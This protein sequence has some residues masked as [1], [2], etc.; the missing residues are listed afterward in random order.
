[1]LTGRILIVAL[2]GWNDATEAASGALSA[3]TEQ[4]DAQTLE[5][6]DPQEYYDFQLF[7]PMV[8]LDEEGNR[9]IIWPSTELLQ[10]SKENI[11]QNPELD[12]LYLLV[13]AEPSRRWLAF[14]AE[15]LEMVQD[16]E[17]DQ[18]IMLGSMFAEV[19]HTRPM[20]V[21]K[22]T[23]NKILQESMQIETSNYEGLV[24][25][26]AILTQAFE[27]EG[28]PVLSLWGSVPHYVHNAINPKGSLGFLN[29]LQTLIGFS[30]DSSALAEAG[31][32]WERS[33]DDAA[34]N[35]DDLSAYIAQLEKNYDTLESE[36]AS[37]DSLAREFE[38]Y[39]QDPPESP[40][41]KGDKKG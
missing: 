10:A 19:P 8:E 22:S 4:T 2:Q 39:L 28:I 16:R 13:G 26:L 9:V 37:G 24:G 25:I 23:Q 33:I 7:R 40:G 12:R 15:I 34:E 41:D 21:F 5:A 11:Q 35:D 14:A 38:R 20:P 32:A 29:E 6:V 27:D 3:I 18:V 17:I 31:F 30:F 36:Q 1:M